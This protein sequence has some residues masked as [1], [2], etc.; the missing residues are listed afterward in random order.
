MFGNLFK[1]EKETF[2][3][4]KTKSQGKSKREFTTAAGFE[5]TREFPSGFLVHR[6]NRSARQPNSSK[7]FFPGMALQI[8]TKNKFWN[9]KIK[10]ALLIH[11]GPALVA[12][13]NSA[14]A[15]REVFT[16]DVLFVN[17]HVFNEQFF[18]YSM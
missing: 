9:T 5:P 8:E 13:K 14:D 4:L 15:C 1:G 11:C 17:K 6:L 7:L 3:D 10:P 2:F 18:N 12:V 16:V